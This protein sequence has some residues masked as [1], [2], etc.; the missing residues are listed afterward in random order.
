MGIQTDV[1]VV[2]FVLRKNLALG[3]GTGSQGFLE[4]GSLHRV[5]SVYKLLMP[6]E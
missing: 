1:A 4:N 6:A 3:S 5:N 2:L